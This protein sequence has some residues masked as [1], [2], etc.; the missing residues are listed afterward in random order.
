[1]KLYGL[2]KPPVPVTVDMDSVQLEY[3]KKLVWRQ[4]M[5]WEG[6]TDKALDVTLELREMERAL[7][8]SGMQVLFEVLNGRR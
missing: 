6:K 7:S 1:M 3:I 2:A 5:T 4:L 8:Q